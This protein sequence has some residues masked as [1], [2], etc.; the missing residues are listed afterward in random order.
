M[1]NALPPGP[2]PRDTG[3]LLLH[4]SPLRLVT[5]WTIRRRPLLGA[6]QDGQFLASPLGVLARQ[7]WL[8]LPLEYP[9][10]TFEW[11][12]V[13]PTAVVALVRVPRSSGRDV[14]RGVLAHYKAM[15]TRA[16]RGNRRIWARGYAA[17]PA[18]HGLRVVRDLNRPSM[19]ST[20]AGCRLDQR[21]GVPVALE[22]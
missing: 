17:V 13:Q 19:C 16:D 15:V 7:Y 22:K 9:E 1:T 12:Q 20:G 8:A 11:C 21:D 14:L 3:S 2:P 5:L 4:Q 6:L 10:M 18:A